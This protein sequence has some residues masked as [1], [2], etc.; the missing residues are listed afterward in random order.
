M[1]VGDKVYLLSIGNRRGSK[2]EQG[3]SECVV[4]KVGK[5]YITVSHGHSGCAETQI[6]KDTGLE[7]SHYTPGYRMYLTEQQWLDEREEREICAKIRD[8]FGYSHNKRNLSLKAL[9]KIIHI[10]E[11]SE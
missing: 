7:K 9:R 10:I 8:S 5:K 3:L 6:H 2:G 11:N 1:N 4:K